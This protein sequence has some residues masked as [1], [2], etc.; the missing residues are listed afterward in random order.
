MIIIYEV[1]QGIQKSPVLIVNAFNTPAL[2]TK[3][4]KGTVGT[5]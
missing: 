1:F 4:K 3:K 5:H 2:Q